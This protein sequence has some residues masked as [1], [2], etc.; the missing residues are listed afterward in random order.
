MQVDIWS[1]VGAELDTASPEMCAMLAQNR[2]AIIR[3][4][5]A[6]HSRTPSAVLL[7][8]ALDEH[9]AVR[10]AVAR[11]VNTKPGVLAL[12]ADDY[13]AE[14]RAAAIGPRERA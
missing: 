11:N 14:V 6:V 10:L 8:L 9:A 4:C 3:S 13:E 2:Q 1:I 5:V 12:L 7:V